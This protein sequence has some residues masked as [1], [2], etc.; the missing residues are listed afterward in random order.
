MV[1]KYR[2]PILLELGQLG[3]KGLRGQMAGDIGQ[4]LQ[5]VGKAGLQTQCPAVWTTID[6]LPEGLGR[7]RIAADCKRA[8]LVGNDEAA[9]LDGVAY[10]DRSDFILSDSKA[11]PRAKWLEANHRIACV[12][13]AGEVRPQRVVEHI[14][15]QGPS[16]LL[17]GMDSH[18]T[19]APANHQIREQGEVFD[20]IEMTVGEQNVVDLRKLLERKG[21][22]ERSRVKREGVVDQ[23]ASG[24]IIGQ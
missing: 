21:R 18:R 15:P 6:N 17:G 11:A 13:D 22:G 19:G 5:L 24:P 2:C 3:A 14:G 9:G 12:R 16:A 7:T 8:P 23:K 10:R 20:V 4:L 1:E